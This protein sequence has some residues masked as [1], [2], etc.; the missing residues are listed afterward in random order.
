VATKPE[1]A[2]P[3]AV[4]PG[5]SKSDAVKSDAGDGETETPVKRPFK[6]KKL[7]IFGIIGLLVLALAGGAAWYF[8]SKKNH[9]ADGSEEAA[10]APVHVAPKGPPTYFP[11]E[12]MVVNLAD[13]GGEKVAQVGIT[14]ELA[15]AKAA[16]Q[17]KLYLPSIRSGILLLISQRTAEEILQIDGKEKLAADIILEASRPFE[18]VDPDAPARAKGSKVK[19]RMVSKNAAGQ[20][21]VLGVNFSSFIVQ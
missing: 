6:R 21:P 4:K 7:I 19:K 11:M 10:P 18:E 13:P 12:N 1:T 2:K 14:L 8:L 5:G 17:V 3:E 15:D 16:D 20:N 9:S